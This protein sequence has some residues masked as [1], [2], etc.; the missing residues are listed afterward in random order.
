MN[1]FL[2]L[3]EFEQYVNEN[4]ELPIIGNKSTKA[5][6]KDHISELEGDIRYFKNKSNLI[7][8][9]TKKLEMM[10]DVV[11]YAVNA[12]FTKFYIKPADP[13]AFSKSLTSIQKFGG[14]RLQLK[15]FASHGKNSPI[16]NNFEFTVK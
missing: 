12:D 5:L 10:P 14:N 3:N 2:S 9:L 6:Q 11:S 16:D 8:E 15:G 13:K 1:P 7:I 4:K